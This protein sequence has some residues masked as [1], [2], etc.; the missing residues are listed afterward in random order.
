M[1]SLDLVFLE[2]LRHSNEEA[3]LC[4]QN[5]PMEHHFMTLSVT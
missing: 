2:Q 5:I 3:G 1:N 4:M